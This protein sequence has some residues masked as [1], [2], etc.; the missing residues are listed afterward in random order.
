MSQPKIVTPKR[1]RGILRNLQ[2]E[3]QGAKDKFPPGVPAASGVR[4]EEKE[5][6]GKSSGDGVGHSEVLPVADVQAEEREEEG[7]AK[8]KKAK[9]HKHMGAPVK[10]RKKRTGQGK[11]KL[12][13]L[14][15]LTPSLIPFHTQGNSLYNFK[16]P[17]FHF[18]H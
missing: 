15:P 12:S 9:V 18:T 11:T 13:L 3:T 17:A 4:D 7:S 14:S 1:S 6:Q 16:Q 2:P 8:R 5:A 10:R